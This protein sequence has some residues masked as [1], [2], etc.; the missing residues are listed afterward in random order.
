MPER[1]VYGTKEDWQEVLAAVEAQGPLEYVALGVYPTAEVPIFS[2]AAAIPDLG[3]AAEGEKIVGPRFMVAPHGARYRPE[4]VRQ[5]K[6]GVLYFAEATN[7]RSILFQ[8]GGRFQER[9]LIE[10]EI[11]QTYETPEAKA[12][13]RRFTAAMRGKFKKVHYAYVGA[14]ALALQKQGVLLTHSVAS[15][16]RPHLPGPDEDRAAGR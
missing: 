15:P 13:Y 7:S 8:P 3:Q 2:S 6:G 1:I 12:L 5:R 9:Y 4:R 14:H 10:G 16:G 11:V